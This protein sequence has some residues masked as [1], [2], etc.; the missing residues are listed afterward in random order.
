MKRLFQLTL[1]GIFVLAPGL[2]GERE[3][4]T[5]S[6]RVLGPDGEELLEY[7][8]ATE[9][10]WQE[11]TLLHDS[12]FE[13]DDEGR[14]RGSVEFGENESVV[15]IYSKDRK[16][17]AVHRLRDGMHSNLDI[18]LQRTV[19]VRGEVTCE[20]LGETPEWF[21][22]YW[23]I[24]EA[25]PI[26]VDSTKGKFDLRLPVGF[27]EYDL[28]DNW[29]SSLEGEL[30]L[31]GRLP[32]VNLGKLDLPAAYIAKNRGKVLDEWSP[33]AAK[34][35]RL[36]NASLSALRGKWVLVE[37][38]GHQWETCVEES[39]PELAR[40]YRNHK[41][42][43]FEIIA[44]HDSTVRGFVQLDRALAG[45]KKRHWQDRDLPFPVLIDG[46]GETFFKF[47]IQALPTTILIDP[48][49]RLVGLG[50]LDLLRDALAGRLEV[51]ETR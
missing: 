27:W 36:Q 22:V 39:L 11:G 38:W 25:Y 40:F 51:G 1:A 35:I 34:N 3:A 31:D 13:I 15:V 37:F 21:N 41:S 7:D 48:E 43:E 14:F 6:G 29:F 26:G 2:A 18:E 8:I 44:F 5:V 45:V 20:E 23:K 30:P 19:R 46:D 49:G 50:S 24:H 28:Y 4:L 9:F 10:T 17:G 12:E 47:G 42:D 32:S 16:Y 33:T